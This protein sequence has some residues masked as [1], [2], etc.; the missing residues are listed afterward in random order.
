[1][2]YIFLTK[3]GPADKVEVVFL[4][5]YHISEACTV[6][7]RAKILQRVHGA[8]WVGVGGDGGEGTTMRT[9]HMSHAI[10][11]NGPSP[12]NKL[13]TKYGKGQICTLLAL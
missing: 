5:V 2:N 3:K 12:L 9:L 11:L 8:G 6:S 1:M 7:A 13:I 10:K 4:V